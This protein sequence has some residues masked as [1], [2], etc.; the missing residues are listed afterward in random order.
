MHIR[1]DYSQPFFGSKSRKKRH[2][3]RWAFALGLLIGGLLLFVSTRM[4][5]I[6]ATAMEM[7]GLVPTATPFPGELAN[8]A[9]TAYRNGD[10]ARAIQLFERTIA[11]RPEELNYLFEYGQI[12]IETG[13]Y[14]RAIELGD[15]AIEQDLFDP[16]GYAVKSR[17]LVWSGDSSAGVSVALSGL[18]VDDQ[19]APLYAVLAR[20]YASL[21]SFSTALENG[22]KAVQ[23]DPQSPEARRSY[24][25]ALNSV[26]AREEATAQ[27]ETGLLLDSSYIP[28]YFELAAQYL[29]QDRDRDAISLYDQVLIIQPNNARAYLRLC[30]A[31]RK[32]GE[33]VR[34]E[35]YC[36]NAV[37][38]DPTYTAAQFRLG[39]IKYSKR[40]FQPALNAFQACSDVN[41]ELLECYYRLGL[42][43]YYLSLE[44]RARE[45]M[46][47]PDPTATPRL[48]ATPMRNEMLE[49]ALLQITEEG[50]ALEVETATP[51]ITALPT[52][53]GLSSS[54]HCDR[55]WSIL[56]ES[57]TLAQTTID[58][59]ETVA[60]IRLGLSLV[61]QDCPKF[62][63][64]APTLTPSETPTPSATPT[65]DP[66]AFSTEEVLDEG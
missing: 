1:R 51:T 25:F 64:A 10:T 56:Q 65:I 61:A 59:D 7:L 50:I 18:A 21:G 31:Y 44:A 14:D 2:Y 27:L 8:Q 41:P 24:A 36:E 38:A 33:F 4:E 66:E 29:A 58:N 54:E 48:D 46:V 39:M 23:L 9:I 17:A 12:L 47:A 28:L 30:D 62:R 22:E 45:N 60:D 15:Q 49:Q 16:Q 3:G 19:F 32:I 6:E 35:D 42:T 5:Q 26:N 63:G 40:E 13:N 34:G 11:E 52:E 57:L 20:A 53:Q 55:A 37:N 43:H